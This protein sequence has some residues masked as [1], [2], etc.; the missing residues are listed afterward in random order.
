[1]TEASQNAISLDPSADEM[2]R[3]GN[4]AVEAMSQYLSSIDQQR[5]YPNTSAAEIRQKLETALPVEG[6]SFDHL[7]ATFTN[8]ITPLSRA[9]AHQRRDG[10]SKSG[11]EKIEAAAF[12]G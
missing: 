3:W 1:M 7:L 4:A 12:N 9:N 11:K 10:V 5:V 8:A 6:S 2:R